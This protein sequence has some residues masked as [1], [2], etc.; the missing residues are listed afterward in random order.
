MFGRKSDPPPPEVI[1]RKVESLRPGAEPE[2]VDPSEVTQ[3]ID[4]AVQ[5]LQAAQDKTTG[6]LD[7]ALEKLH[8][9]RRASQVPTE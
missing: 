7:A 2:F 6:A 3:V 9:A 8:G 5:R 4:L 1:E